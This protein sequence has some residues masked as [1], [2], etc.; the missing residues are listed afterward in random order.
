MQIWLASAT[1][2]CLCPLDSAP[3]LLQSFAFSPWTKALK[4]D[5]ISDINI[6]H[7]MSMLCSGIATK[8]VDIIAKGKGARQLVLAKTGVLCCAIPETS[9]KCLIFAYCPRQALH[10]TLE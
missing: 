2:H 10:L 4:P 3:R 6:L 7:N 1:R 9:K 5:E 8:G